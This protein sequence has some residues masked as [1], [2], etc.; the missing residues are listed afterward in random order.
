MWGRRGGGGD[1]GAWERPAPQGLTG[2][3]RATLGDI[4]CLYNGCAGCLLRRA[5]VWRPD[6]DRGD[7]GRPGDIADGDGA[8]IA[9]TVYAIPYAIP[10]DYIIARRG[11]STGRQRLVCAPTEP[12]GRA[13]QLNA[14]RG[15]PGPG[16][17]TVARL[18]ER[19]TRLG[20]TSAASRHYYRTALSFALCSPRPSAASPRAD[21]ATS[22]CG[23]SY[24]DFFSLSFSFAPP[25]CF[26]ALRATL[27]MASMAARTPPNVTNFSSIAPSSLLPDSVLPANEPR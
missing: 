21:H 26:K 9:N 10:Y 16:D 3:A 19:R 22:K 1:R 2:V 12:A 11:D 20:Y 23:A 18:W 6:A 14:P 17:T 24:F 13:G 7:E 5:G 27:P 4:G 8:G 15:R 25:C